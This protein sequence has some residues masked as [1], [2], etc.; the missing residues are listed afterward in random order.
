MKNSSSVV[1]LCCTLV[2]SLLLLKLMCCQIEIFLNYRH[3]YNYI[4]L[5][6]LIKKLVLQSLIVI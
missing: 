6:K 5:K 1:L 2:H 4:Q 3:D